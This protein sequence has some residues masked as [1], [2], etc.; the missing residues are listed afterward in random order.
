[1]SAAVF[2]QVNGSPKVMLKEFSGIGLSVNSRKDAGV[3]GTVDNPVNCGKV[4][5]VFPIT[6]VS[7]TDIDTEITQRFEI[8]LTPLAD[9]AVDSG[10]WLRSSLAITDPAKPQIPVIRIF[11]KEREG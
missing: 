5:Y 7:D 8:C 2:E 11:I 6:D 9:E 10:D 3:G 1:M 4:G